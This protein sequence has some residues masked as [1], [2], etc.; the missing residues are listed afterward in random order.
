MPT[1]GNS[2]SPLSFSSLSGV[3][4]MLIAAAGA[5]ILVLL[6]EWVFSS[7]QD[8]NRTDPSSPATLKRAL[9]LRVERL[10]RDIMRYWFSQKKKEKLTT[11]TCK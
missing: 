5:S 11:L 7:F 6:L 2:F 8:V 4:I 1:E 10:K 3:F 9:V